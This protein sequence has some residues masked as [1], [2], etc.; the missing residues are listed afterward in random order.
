MQVYDILKVVDNMKRAYLINSWEESREYFLRCL[1]KYT[2]EEY[3]TLMN[4][5]VV[6]RGDNE[7]TIENVNG[8]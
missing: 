6:Y 7:F 5:G 1:G 2:E 8:L 3:N 4:G